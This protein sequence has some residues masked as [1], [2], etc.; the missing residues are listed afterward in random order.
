MRWREGLVIWGIRE[1]FVEH[2]SLLLDLKDGKTNRWAFWAKITPGE[3]ARQM[4]GGWWLLNQ[5]TYGGWLSSQT[6]VQTISPLFF[7]FLINW[8]LTTNSPLHVYWGYF[9]YS[10]LCIAVG[11]KKTPSH[12][13]LATNDVGTWSLLRCWL[14]LPRPFGFGALLYL[15]YTQSLGAPGWARNMD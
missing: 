8:P 11:S 5:S 9:P 3:R 13:F 7:S 12:R 14:W 1:G 15:L 2:L 4:W 10:G 6:C